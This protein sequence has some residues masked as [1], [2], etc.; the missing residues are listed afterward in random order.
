MSSMKVKVVCTEQPQPYAGEIKEKFAPGRYLIYSRFNG[1]DQLHIREYGVKTMS[2]GMGEC[3]YPTKKGVCLTLN[4]VKALRNA[5]DE[6][7]E[8]LG[9]KPVGST[10]FKVHLGAAIYASINELDG[11]DFRRFW[12]P[13]GQTEI[14]PTKR[15]IFITISQWESFK[16]KFNLMLT[17]CPA[18][19]GAEEHFH[20]NQME[21]IDCRECLPFGY[22]M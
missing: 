7:D 11:V 22:I 18:L 12:I 3:E 8:R 5:I 4:R 14:I 17:S 15:G 20:Q 21:L 6:I 13:E 2:N 16:E 10:P 1:I 19:S 9:V